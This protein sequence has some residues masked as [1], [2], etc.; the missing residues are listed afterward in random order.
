MPRDFAPH[1]YFESLIPPLRDNK[2]LIELIAKITGESLAQVCARFR[3]EHYHMGSNVSSALRAAGIKPFVWCAALAKFYETTDAFLYE[4]I[5]WNRS[6]LK[7]NLR[8]WIGNYLAQRPPQRVLAFGDGL[9]I[10]S[11]Y[12]ASL[13]H[14]VTYCEVSQTCQLFARGLFDYSSIQVTMLNN[15][16]HLRP[17]SFDVIICLDVLEHIPEPARTVA[18]LSG[19]L[20]SGGELIVH[21]PFHCISSNTPTHLVENVC[22]SGETKTLYRLHGLEPVNGRLFWNPLVLRKTNSRCDGLHRPWQVRAGSLL[23]RVAKYWAWP[24]LIV[25]NL[26]LN[27]R[28]LIAFVI[29]DQDVRAIHRSPHL[30]DRRADNPSYESAKAL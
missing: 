24:H 16:E 2:F 11:Y 7:N 1:R 25:G 12:L 6:S 14:E 30:F 8:A 3:Q 28:E 10:D 17:E 27:K 13:R 19:L 20:R 22:Y 21:A 26:L 5:V 18:W 4:T 29:D 23:L 15:P 9:G